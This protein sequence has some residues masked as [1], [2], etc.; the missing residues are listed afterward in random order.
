VSI[1]LDSKYVNG[2]TSILRDL[3]KQNH[4][5]RYYRYSAVSIIKYEADFFVDSVTIWT[6]LLN[7]ISDLKK[8]GIISIHMKDEDIKLHE[9]ELEFDLP[10]PGLVFCEMEGF[11][12]VNEDTFCSLDYNPNKRKDP[13][14]GSKGMQRSFITV[15]NHDFG[16]KLLLCFS[17]KYKLHISIDDLMKSKQD[18]L[19]YLQNFASIYLTQA[20][21]PKYFSVA[22]GYIPFIEKSTQTSFLDMLNKANWFSEYRRRNICKNF[23]GGVL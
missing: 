5:G 22:K 6:A 3:F 19:E 10:Y 20:T 7:R 21:T 14:R 4:L 12:K 13:S 16:L 23:L 2:I 1:L 9:I 18:L 15:S 17:R 8:R 11:R